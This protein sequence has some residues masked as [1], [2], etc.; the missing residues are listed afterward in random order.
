MRWGSKFT[1][2]FVVVSLCC[3]AM[4]SSVYSQPK[5]ETLFLSGKIV[6]KISFTSTRYSGVY[7]IVRDDQDTLWMCRTIDSE[8]T[9][10]LKEYREDERIAIDGFF[11][12]RDGRHIQ[13]ATVKKEPAQASSGEDSDE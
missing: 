11:L 7:L 8:L 12:D 5:E 3:L 4:F 1:Y 10:E 6:D 9:E 13:I 2:S